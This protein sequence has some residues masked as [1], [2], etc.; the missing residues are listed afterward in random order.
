MEIQDVFQ[1]LGSCPFLASPNPPK[2]KATLIKVYLAELSL[3]ASLW[4]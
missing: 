2:F 4:A 3:R 1:G